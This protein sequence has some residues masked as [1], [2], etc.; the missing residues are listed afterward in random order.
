MVAWMENEGLQM[1]ALSGPSIWGRVGGPPG[2]DQ[3]PMRW[4]MA[5]WEG[6]A[7]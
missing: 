7:A 5:G 2:R 6:P 4:V 3:G 1:R